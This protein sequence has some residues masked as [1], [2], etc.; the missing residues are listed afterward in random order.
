MARLLHVVAAGL[1]SDDAGAGREQNLIRVARQLYRFT[2]PFWAIEYRVS[3][4]WQFALGVYLALR[5]TRIANGLTFSRH[6][7][8]LLWSTYL[9]FGVLAL[10]IPIPVFNSTRDQ[11]GFV[12]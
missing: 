5:P 10:T 6:G 8:F 9:S 1:G 7:Q 11:A 3:Q 4:S 2:Y 12:S